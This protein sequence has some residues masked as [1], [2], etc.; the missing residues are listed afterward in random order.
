MQGKDAVLEMAQRIR[1][2]GIPASALWVFDE[3]DEPNN[4][5]WPFWFASY[6][7]DP[8]AFNDTLHDQGYKVLGYV[9]PYVREQM[10]PYPTRAPP[11]KKE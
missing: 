3:L 2:E 9:H 5:G 11:I 1:T 6:Y 8:R 7:G 10:L 4:L